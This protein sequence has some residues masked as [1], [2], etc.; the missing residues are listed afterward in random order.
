MQPTVTHRLC[1]RPCSSGGR[2]MYW[3][4]DQACT[5]IWPTPPRPPRPFGRRGRPPRQV[6]PL[7]T[8]QALPEVA[9]QGP[10]NAWQTVR[11]RLGQKGPLVRQAVLLPIWCWKAGYETGLLL[12]LLVSCELDGT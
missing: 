5:S 8:A 7:G 6:K 2:R 3:T 10:A 12:Q 1:A 4:W 11:Y 9:A